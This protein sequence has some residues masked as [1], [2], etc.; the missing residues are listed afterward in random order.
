MSMLQTGPHWE[1]YSYSPIPLDEKFFILLA[2][3]VPIV[4]SIKLLRIWRKVP[5]FRRSQPGDSLEYLNQVRSTALSLRHWSLLPFFGWGFV[6]LHRLYGVLNYEIINKSFWI[7][8]AA[9]DMRD[10]AIYLS[11]ALGA[12]II[13]F[14]LR[15]HILL[16]LQRLNH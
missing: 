11:V 7:R 9:M 1:L 8:G 2:L 16:R 3:L 14:L 4:A 15:W 10:L 6:A 13:V 12:F 5:P